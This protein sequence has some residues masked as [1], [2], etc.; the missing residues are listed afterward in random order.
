[1]VSFVSNRHC[2]FCFHFNL[3]HPEI[4]ELKLKHEALE[5]DADL[6]QAARLGAGVQA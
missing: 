3:V 5:S 1:M 2:S 6:L 4:E